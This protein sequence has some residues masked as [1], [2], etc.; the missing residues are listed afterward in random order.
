ML[1]T[2]AGSLEVEFELAAIRGVGV[3]G[4]ERPSD[5]ADEAFH[6][7][8]IGIGG[9]TPF[10]LGE[11]GGGEV[12]ES[13]RLDDQHPPQTCR[14]LTP[15][16]RDRGQAGDRFGPACDPDVGVAAFL[17][18]LVADQGEPLGRR[19]VAEIGDRGIFSLRIALNRL[20][21]MARV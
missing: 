11:P 5:A 21:S 1:N 4:R 3:R 13:D 20:S 15:L 10:R 8:H 17:P 9:G 2:L 18:G 12:G 7:D 6:V 19:Q 16:V 14:H